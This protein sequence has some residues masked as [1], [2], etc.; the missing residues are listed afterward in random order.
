MRLVFR[1][2]AL[3]GFILTAGLIT[4]IVLDIRHFDRTQGGEE[5]PYEGVTGERI[6]WN[7]F[8]LTREGLVKRGYVL[9]TH[10]NG[11][12][13]LVTYELF[14]LKIP[15]R[16]LSQRAIAVHGA[17]HAFRQRGFDPQF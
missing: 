6:D 14:T 17:R 9:D 4:G 13:G 16:T 15:F 11:T 3:I 10:I 8:D 5:P 7:S 1:F 12:T 2:F